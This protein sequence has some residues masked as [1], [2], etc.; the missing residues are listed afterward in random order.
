VRLF[1]QARRARD[2]VVTV[3]TKLIKL[4]ACEDGNVVHLCRAQAFGHNSQDVV[5]AGVDKAGMSTVAHEG[6]QYS[7]VECTRLG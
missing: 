6:A 2:S 7:A 3:A 5:D 4:D 1:L